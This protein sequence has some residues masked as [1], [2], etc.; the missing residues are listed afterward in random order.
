[1]PRPHVCPRGSGLTPCSAGAARVSNFVSR[2]PARLGARWCYAAGQAAGGEVLLPAKPYWA[3]GRARALPRAAA[4]LRQVSPRGEPRGR[5]TGGVLR[6]HW[7][8]PTS[9]G[10]QR[11]RGNAAFISPW[12]RNR[13][14]GSKERNLRLTRDWTGGL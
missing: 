5:A 3:R 14:S 13:A 12:P 8:V 10:V 9:S 7:R 6:G 2:S 11:F 1:M 4:R